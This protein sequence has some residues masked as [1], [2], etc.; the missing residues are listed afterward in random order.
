[1]SK[2]IAIVAGIVFG[3][4]ARYWLAPE[5]LIN[6]MSVNLGL[7]LYCASFLDREDCDTFHINTDNVYSSNVVCCVVGL[8]RHYCC[9][10]NSILALGVAC[11]LSGII[12]IFASVGVGVH[13]EDDSDDSWSPNAAAM[14]LKLMKY[15]WAFYV[16][17]AGCSL[18]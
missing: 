8:V 13:L 11:L 7:Y 12:G 1:M 17:C 15:G 16:Y 4:A 3:L 5:D 2:L 18:L 10:R 14:D 9:G 6:N